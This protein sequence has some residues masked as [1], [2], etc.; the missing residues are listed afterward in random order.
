MYTPPSFA[1]SDPETLFQFLVQHS[2]ATLVSQDQAGL[3]ASHLP[4]LLQ[5]DAHSPAKLLGHQARA[6]PQWQ[7]ADGQQVLAIFQGPHAYI[8]PTWYE[9]ERAVPTWNYVAVHVTGRLRVITDAN[10]LRQ[11]IQQ[12]VD[13]YEATQPVPWK[14]K[15]QDS[16]FIDGLLKAITGFEIEIEHIEGQWK[17]NQNHDSARRRRVITALQKNS[18]P[19]QQ[20]IAA[21]MQANVEE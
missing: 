17:L 13:V 9:V 21:L 16:A 14:L 8:S 12:T 7:D 4:L 11:I 10:E 15:D 1:E 6:N 2:F 18:D 20:Q 19:A 3:V 5:Q